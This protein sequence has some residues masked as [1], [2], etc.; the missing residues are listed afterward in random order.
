[1]RALEQL[2]PLLQWHADQ[3]GAGAASLPSRPLVPQ[4]AEPAAR[5]QTFRFGSPGR[6]VAPAVLL[7]RQFGRKPVGCAIALVVTA[8]CVVLTVYLFRSLPSPTGHGS[9]QEPVSRVPASASHLPSAELLRLVYDETPPAARV[10]GPVRFRLEV[11]FRRDR[12]GE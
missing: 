6:L 9:G 10:G 1:V 3:T 7:G 2:L 11:R 12:R 8:A 5:R 4:T